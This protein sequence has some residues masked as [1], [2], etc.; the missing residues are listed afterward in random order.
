MYPSPFPNKRSNG[1]RMGVSFL[2]FE[3][4]TFLLFPIVYSLSCPLMYNESWLWLYEKIDRVL[5]A[6]VSPSS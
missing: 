3:E 5:L 2:V 4:L 6:S 1:A